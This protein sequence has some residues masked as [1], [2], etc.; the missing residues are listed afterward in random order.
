MKIIF[1]CK[2]TWGLYN[3]FTEY[4]WLSTAH[5]L[6]CY[7]P[8]RVFM[9]VILHLIMCQVGETAL[10]IKS[11]GQY[12]PVRSLIKSNANH[13]GNILQSGDK[14]NKTLSVVFMWKDPGQW[15]AWNSPKINQSTFLHKTKQKASEN[16]SKVRRAALRSCWIKVQHL[17][18]RMIM[19]NVAANCYAWVTTGYTSTWRLAL[20]TGFMLNQDCRTLVCLWPHL[21]G[22]H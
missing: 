18:C 8:T 16:R 10:K 14:M 22:Y 17:S 2:I 4:K 7:Q 13:K 11:E 5:L 21:H 15:S 20:Q 19:L 9:V 12:H 3:F 6:Q 1:H